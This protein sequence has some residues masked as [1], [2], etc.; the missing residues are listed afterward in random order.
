M[1]ISKPRSAR[2][3]VEVYLVA[4]IDWDLGFKGLGITMVV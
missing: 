3:A 4:F 1:A 2:S